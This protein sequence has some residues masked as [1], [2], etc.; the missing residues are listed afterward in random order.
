MATYTLPVLM[1]VLL[2]ACSHAFVQPAQAPHAREGRFSISPARTTAPATSTSEFGA[3]PEVGTAGI[4][5]SSG[6]IG[7]VLGW[8]RAQRCGTKSMAASAGVVV[9][10][11]PIV[12]RAISSEMGSSIAVAG[13]EEALFYTWILLATIITLVLTVVLREAPRI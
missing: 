9:G 5:L 3:S 2:V 11:V 8:L 12:A 1:T 4:F 6:C 10:A 7:A 13:G